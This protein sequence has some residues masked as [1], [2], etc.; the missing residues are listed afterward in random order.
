MLLLSTPETELQHNINKINDLSMKWGLVINVDKSKFTIFS[1]NGRVSKGTFIFSGGQ[2][3]LECVD[4]Y[5]YLGVSVVQIENFSS[6]K[7][8]KCQS[9]QSFIFNKAK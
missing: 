3:R 8:V 2:T 6:C 5:K 9:K 4:Q 1:K 7:D